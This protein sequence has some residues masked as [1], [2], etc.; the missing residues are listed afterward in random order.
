ML[1]EIPKPKATSPPEGK[2]EVDEKTKETYDAKLL[3][4]LTV[5]DSLQGV[6][7]STC[8][9]DPISHGSNLK[10]C[11][12]MWAKFELL[13]RDTGFMERDT[14]FIRLSSKTA[15]DFDDMAHF[16]RILKR[17]ST[18]LKEIGTKDVPDGM[19]TTWL[20]NCLT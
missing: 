12:D 18:R 7:R 15:S 20:L 14:I 1:D 8:N 4:W 5:T 10:L 17:N 16:A 3:S 9:L 2:E 11:S 13:Y 6:I 19:F